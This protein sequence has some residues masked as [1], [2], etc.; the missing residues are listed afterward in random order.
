METVCTNARVALSQS[1]SKPFAIREPW[2]AILENQQKN[3]RK[4]SNFPERS[5]FYGRKSIQNFLS[6]KKRHGF[7]T[8][9]FQPPKIEVSK[10]PPETNPL[11]TPKFLLIPLPETNSSPPE[12]MGFSPKKKRKTSP[13]AT[14]F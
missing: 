2:G 8:R 11:P 3:C 6:Q 1:P 9:K 5:I 14:H 10:M 13:F 12:N 7:D 4:P